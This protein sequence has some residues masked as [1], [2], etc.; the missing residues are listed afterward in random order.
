[1]N[2]RDWI[3]SKGL[4]Q[5]DFAKQIDVSRAHLSSVICGTRPA[6]RKLAKSIQSATNGEITASSVLIGD[7]VGYEGPVKRMRANHHFSNKMSALVKSQKEISCTKVFSL[8]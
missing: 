6:G 3:L 8:I 7:T 5:E 1:M 2:L 4:R